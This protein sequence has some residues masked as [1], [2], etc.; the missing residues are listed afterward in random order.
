M[1]IDITQQEREHMMGVLT[2]LISKRDG[3]IASIRTATD[4]EFKQG[5]IEQ[6]DNVLKQRVEAMQ[7]MITEGTL[8][9]RV[10]IAAL[11]LDIEEIPSPPKTELFVYTST[12]V[13]VSQQDPE[14]VAQMYPFFQPPE[15]DE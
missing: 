6:F 4:P 15:H 5:L 9:I 10:I 1:D 13:I 8:Q 3:V 11:N 12:D 2:E 14:G 7:Q